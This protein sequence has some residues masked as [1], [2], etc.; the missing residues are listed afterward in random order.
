MSAYDWIA[1]ATLGLDRWKQP[2]QPRTTYGIER[3]EAWDQIE[4]HQRAKRRGRRKAL[5]KLMRR[6]IRVPFRRRPL[7]RPRYGPPQKPASRV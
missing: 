7:V 2:R 6:S 4:A 5:M 3:Q 1:L